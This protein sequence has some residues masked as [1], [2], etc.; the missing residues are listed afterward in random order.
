CLQVG[1]SNPLIFDL[2]N[3]FS[4]IK[5]NNFLND[6]NDA[7]ELESKELKEDGVYNDIPEF[8]VIDET[9][10]IV[11]LLDSISIQLNTWEIWYSLLQSYYQIHK[12]SSPKHKEKFND[13]Y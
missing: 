7:K 9:K 3:N 12:H 4:S 8:N 10:E 5:A 1:N 6:L 13:E 2:V 11:E